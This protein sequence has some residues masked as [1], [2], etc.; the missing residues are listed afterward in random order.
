[1]S[2]PEIVRGWIAKA[3]AE[4]SDLSEQA[5]A[6]QQHLAEARRQLMLFYEMLAAITNA[7]VE[8]SAE[9]M[10]IGRAVRER[11]QK[12]AE[13]ILC[14]RGSP[15]RIQGIHAEFIRRRMRLPG[16][17]TPTNIAAHLVA[18]DRFSRKGRGIYGLV[19]WDG[20]SQSAGS[21]PPPGGLAD[22]DPADS[23]PAQPRPS[24]TK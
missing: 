6:I 3:E 18:S 5:E 2:D 15:M 19:D 16:R 10:G 13:A 11:V 9:H 22:S 8:V 12:D 24:G 21:S 7:P 20:P 14:D 17:G 23:A 1:M 4:V